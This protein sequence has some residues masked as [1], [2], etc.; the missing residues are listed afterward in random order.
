MTKMSKFA[1][2]AALA[3]SAAS[4]AFAQAYNKGDGTGNALPFAYLQ[5]GAKPAYEVPAAALNQQIAAHETRSN[6]QIA[7]RQNR[8]GRV[9]AV[10]T[11]R[12][13]NFVPPAGQADPSSNS[14]AA[15]GG[16]SVGY[17]QMV[18]TY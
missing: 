11:H 16:G 15:T 18:Q 14:A 2:I 10:E 9:A 13:Y 6:Q 1:L 5:G 8:Q 4:P 12:L 3:M 17:N 7:V